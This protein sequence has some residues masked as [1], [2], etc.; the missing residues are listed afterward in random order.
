M[1]QIRWLGLIAR[2][3]KNRFELL[4][5]R[6]RLKPNKPLMLCSLCQQQNCSCRWQ[7]L[8]QTLAPV[9]N[10]ERIAPLHFHQLSF[11]L[12]YGQQ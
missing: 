8:M 6:A 9:A 7:Q 1:T 10:P 3:K 11:H 5:Y 4:Y 12:V 2:T